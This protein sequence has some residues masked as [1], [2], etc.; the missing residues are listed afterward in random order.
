MA[1]FLYDYVKLKRKS[2]LPRD[3]I[4]PEEASEKETVGEGEE[5]STRKFTAEAS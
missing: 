3:L 4:A 1:V 2:L 5:E